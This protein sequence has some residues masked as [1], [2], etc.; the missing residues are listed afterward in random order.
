MEAEKLAKKER[1]KRKFDEQTI[2][3]ADLKDMVGIHTYGISKR[4]ANRLMIRQK[5]LNAIRH[6]EE[7]ERRNRPPEEEEE[8]L[9]GRV[10]QLPEPYEP[11]VEESR[12][13]QKPEDSDSGF[14]H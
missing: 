8:I 9:V 11:V 2:N 3:E 10:V 4:V 1:K 14:S 13:D 6:A 12:K 5:K 7:L